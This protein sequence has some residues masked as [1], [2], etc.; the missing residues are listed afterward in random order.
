MDFSGHFKFVLNYTVMSNMAILILQI[1]TEKCLLKKMEMNFSYHIFVIYYLF[2][3]VFWILMNQLILF[4][5]V[6][7]TRFQSLNTIFW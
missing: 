5:F 2:N 6:V 3:H 1:L 7:K 4:Q